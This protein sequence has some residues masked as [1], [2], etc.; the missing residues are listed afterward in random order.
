MFTR[1]RVLGIVA[2]GL[3]GLG[4]AIASFGG[5]AE[6]PPV[7]SQGE[8]G[9]EGVT[10]PPAVVAKPP[11]PELE[12]RPFVGDAEPEPRRMSPKVVRTM[13]SWWKDQAL[14]AQREISGLLRAG[15]E[16][17]SDRIR[18]VLE[19]LRERTEERYDREA[20]GTHR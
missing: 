14:S 13:S 6:N 5:A 11:L 1:N 19:T 7:P 8:Q 18:S 12:V 20:S 10:T 17:S 9:G 16:D 2:L 3:F 15:P 4:V